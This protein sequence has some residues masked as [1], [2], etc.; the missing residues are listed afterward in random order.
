MT[1]QRA[2]PPGQLHRLLRSG[3]AIPG[4]GSNAIVATAPFRAVGGFDETFTFAA[5]WELWLRLVDR[6]TA[7]AERRPLTARSLHDANWAATRVADV[8]ADLERLAARHGVS[9]RRHGPDQ[10]IAY[11]LWLSGR[12]RPAA[13]RYLRAAVHR[14]DPVSLGR[15]ALAWMPPSRV[16]RL[17]RS[18]P[19]VPPT[20]LPAGGIGPEP[21][22]TEPGPGRAPARRPPDEPAVARPRHRG[23]RSRARLPRPDRTSGQCPP[24]PARDPTIRVPCAIGLSP[25]S[26]EVRP[27]PR[28]LAVGRE[29]GGRFRVALTFDDD[30][31]SHISLAAPVLDHAGLPATFFLTGGALGGPFRRW[32][33][34]LADAESEDRWSSMVAALAADWPWAAGCTRPREL[35]KTIEALAPGDRDCIERRLREL[36]TGAG[37]DVGVDREAVAALRSAGF[38]IGFH[39]RDHHPLTTLDDDQLHVAMRAGHDELESAAQSLLEAI[40]YPHGA[41]DLRVA[42]AARAAGFKLG[43]MTGGRPIRRDDPPLL[44]DRI[45]PAAFGDGAGR[46]ALALSRALTAG[47]DRW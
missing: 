28:S 42:A 40:A 4:G 27:R 10:Q 5:D 46:F 16:A 36:G 12:W 41:A 15:A 21:Y 3:N 32:W 29:R 47:P 26:L 17:R 35:A 23:G 34:D 30:L 25:A 8:H 1:I 9:L 45:D 13:S 11:A 19:L 18:P 14:R 44:L 43:Y 37:S 31:R 6:V 33:H 20:W 2:P 7:V 24:P 38:E 39:T 22:R